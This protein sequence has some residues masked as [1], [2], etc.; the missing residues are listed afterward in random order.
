MSLARVEKRDGRLVPFDAAKIAAAIARAMDAVGEPDDG[1][2][3]E[4]AGVVRM[5]LEERHG[6]TGPGGPGG[7]GSV[8]T[9]EEIQD[10]VEQALIE[11]GRSRVAKAYILYR[12]Q[13]ARARAALRTGREGEGGD[14]KGQRGSRRVRVR[15]AE[16]TSP[17]SKGRIVAALMREADLSRELSEKVAAR[18]E[19]RVFQAG[20]PHVSTALVRELVEAELVAMGLESARRRQTSFGLPAFDLRQLL[21]ARP[22]AFAASR[23]APAEGLAEARVEGRVAGEVLARFSLSELLG[24]PRGAHLGAPGIGP[25]GSRGAHRPAG[26]GDELAE[27]HRAGDLHVHELG[28]PQRPLW[29]AVPSATLSARAT[30]EGAFELLGEL[31]G[32]AAEVVHGIALEDPLSALASLSPGRGSGR[33]G[34]L[35]AWL[36]ALTAVARAAGRRIDLSAPGLRSPVLF[37]RLLRELALQ[38]D[39][40]FA[41]RLFVDEREL[42]LAAGLAEGEPAGP[43][44]G[45]FGPALD[46]LLVTGRV[47]PC[48]SSNGE[49][50]VAPGCHRA[51]GER[52]AITCGVAVSINLPRIALRAGP[53]R[54]DRLLERFSEAVEDAVH[55]ALALLSARR[56]TRPLGGRVGA[57]VSPVGL[58]EALEIAGDGVVDADLGARLLGFLSDAL[59]RAEGRHRVR[60]VASSAFGHGAAARFAE[61]D[62]KLPQR[63]QRLLFDPDEGEAGVGAGV[64]YAPG[65]AVSSPARALGQALEGWPAEARLVATVPVGA[66]APLPIRPEGWV[67]G[68]AT[69]HAGALE[70][71]VA[72]AVLRCLERRTQGDAEPA[73]EAGERERLLPRPGAPEATEPPLFPETTATEPVPA[74]RRP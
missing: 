64:P 66:L 55:A 59:G 71:G 18:V 48:W 50:V 30:P 68:L 13:R 6:T 8:P 4:V 56:G 36:R 29:L 35:G 74:D 53:W 60:F 5:T 62:R 17:W 40:A 15:E 21:E 22:P 39:D 7:S 58:R 51:P 31:A 9:I 32:L 27:R 28:A 25:G 69:S 20:L 19:Q 11:L 44:A 63:A 43:R 26:D 24:A 72:R 16:G 42:E 3:G 46:R 1:F 2:A 57:A 33:A 65:F 14:G 70:S 37:E 10:L 52:A 38:A 34:S 67:Q 12:D 49:R 61:L 54:E 23:P 41:P 73:A 45:G 47:V